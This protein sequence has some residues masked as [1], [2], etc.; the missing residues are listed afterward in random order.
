MYFHT[1]GHRYYCMMMPSHLSTADRH[2]DHHP[3]HLA[4]SP[5]RHLAFWL[6]SA[7]R[8]GPLRRVPPPS[9]EDTWS[10]RS[11]VRDVSWPPPGNGP[12]SMGSG[13]AHRHI[14]LRPTHLQPVD[15][16]SV[17]LPLSWC[18]STPQTSGHR[19]ARCCCM[20]MPFNVLSYFRPPLLLHDDAISFVNR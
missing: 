4:T 3:C 5:P 13:A 6:V 12:T 1:S 11:S 10:G 18:S 7:P 2:H 8:L 20:M 15:S 14:C 9:P 19:T 17:R 16:Q